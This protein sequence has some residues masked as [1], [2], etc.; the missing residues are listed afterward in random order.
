LRAKS[1]A[2]AIADFGL[3]ISDFFVFLFQ[4]AFR[5]LQSAIWRRAYRAPSRAPL[6]Q[7]NPALSERMVC[8][9]GRENESCLMVFARN[10]LASGPGNA[11]HSIPLA[12]IWKKAGKRQKILAPPRLMLLYWGRSN[13]Q[14][15]CKAHAVSSP[16][17]PGGKGMPWFIQPHDS[18]AE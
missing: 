15:R 4:S 7:N 13:L 16:L 2:A 17:N 8:P 5:N 12:P 1:I 14:D 11:G 6:H 9:P 18:S 10:F 3:R